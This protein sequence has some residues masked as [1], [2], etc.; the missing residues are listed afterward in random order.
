MTSRFAVL[1]VLFS[2]FGFICSYITEIISKMP[3]EGASEFVYC[4]NG[5]FAEAIGMTIPEDL[6]QYVIL[7]NGVNL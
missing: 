1:S 3:I 5:D 6:Q 2:F 4:I 7:H